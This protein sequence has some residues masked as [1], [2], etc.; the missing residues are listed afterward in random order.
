MI[1]KIVFKTNPWRKERGVLKP[2]AKPIARS[3]Y[4]SELFK[5]GAG[6]K[7]E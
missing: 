4:A 1:K 7:N 2:D 3:K 5:I 6:W